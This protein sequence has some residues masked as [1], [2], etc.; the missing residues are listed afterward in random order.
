MEAIRLAPTKFREGDDNGCVCAP[1]LVLTL[2]EGISGGCL[3]AEWIG[4]LV[5]LGS[6]AA[7]FV[8]EQ[9]GRQLVVAVSV[10]SREFA[11]ALIGCG[12]VMASTSPTLADPLETLRTIVPGTPVRAINGHQIISGLFWA[13]NDSV[14]PPRVQIDGSIWPVDRFTALVVLPEIVASERAL[15]PQP[16][17]VGR[18]AKLDQNWDARLAAPAADLAIVG[19][20]AWLKDDFDAL[21]GREGDL[22]PAPI[23][24]LLLPDTGELGT[25]FTRIYTSAHLAVHLPLPE[26]LR[27]VIL[28]GSG[29]IKY[30]QCIESPLVVCVIDRSVADET[31]AENLVQL[32]NSRGESVSLPQDLNWLAPAGV[33]ALAFTVPL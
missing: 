12:W 4:R 26:D 7:R 18:L 31:A 24:D 1:V 30:I 6:R 5:L 25:W 22:D 13:L 3:A 17:S 15:R 27:A 23:H 2:A 10:P 29:A 20:S 33:E 11:A 28:D 21:L 14:S 9:P 16:G 8:R 32:R 19:T